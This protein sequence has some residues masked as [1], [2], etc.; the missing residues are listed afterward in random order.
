V[1]GLFFN[2][3]NNLPPATHPNHFSITS[4]D[5]STPVI[6]I[7]FDPA[8]NP[9]TSAGNVFN[10]TNTAE[11]PT[12]LR[13]IKLVINNI[14]ATFPAGAPN[15]VAYAVYLRGL[16]KVR[17]LPLPEDWGNWSDGYLSRMEDPRPPAITTLPA[18]VQFTAMPDATK[19]G[20]GRLTWPVAANALGY[21][22]W[23]ASETAVRAALDVH[24]KTQFPGD[25]SKH[26]KPLTDSLVD[27]A[28]QLRDL[29]AQTQ[30][31]NLCQRAFNKLTREMI[32]ETSVELEIQASSKVLTLYQVSSINTANIESGKSN[33]VFFAV[34]QLHKPAAPLLMLRK[35]KREDP[36]THIEIK[37]IQVQVLNGIG[38]IP[39]GFNLYRSRKMLIGNDAGTKGLPVK[40]FDSADWKAHSM[41]MPDGT[42]YNGR[43][44]EETIVSGSWR[45]FV[46]QVVAIGEEDGARGFFRGESD[47]SSTEAIFFPPESPPT[48]IIQPP[49]LSNTHSKVL[50]LSTSAP[51]DLIEIGKTIIEL[52]NLDTNNK[53]T[54]L[55]IFVASDTIISA[56]DLAPVSAVV[57]ATWPAISRKTTDL[58]TGITQ[59]SV[60][61]NISVTRLLIRIIDPLGRATE[62][63]EEA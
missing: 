40:E 12:D 4:V 6:T 61:I 39:S 56:T 28:T 54:L 17:A 51:F 44:V 34:P 25:P 42:V 38:L 63:S 9:A 19:L 11:T 1:A 37:G 55:K 26:L 57:A 29:L 62:A 2:A 53:R 58:T 47:P 32:R 18:T 45:P 60:G 16:E 14:T 20:R 7:S 22:V 15:A 30:Y 13:K 31:Q 46:Y 59:F 52:Y 23:E 36:I 5:V 21:Y 10:V 35:F 33:V 49:L 24:L 48:L 3:A 41:R 50:R 8:G 27:R 43:Y